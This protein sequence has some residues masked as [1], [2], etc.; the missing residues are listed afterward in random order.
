MMLTDMAD[1]LRAGGLAVQ[2]HAGWKTRT[3]TD[4]PFTPRGMMFHHDASPVGP[5]PSVPEYL[6]NTT[7]P[8]AQ[9]WVDTAGTWHTIAAGRMWHA[10]IG[11]GWG[12]IPAQAGNTY[13]LGVETDHTTGEAWPAAQLG[14]IV[15]G[16][17]VLCRR[18]GWDP[19]HAVCGHK[20]YAPGRKVDPAPL[21]MA[22]FR[23]ALGS[24]PPPPPP[25]GPPA[26]PRW[27]LPQGHYYGLI[28]GPAV[29]HGGYSPDERPV[30][31][32]LQQRLIA[33]GYVP[34][35]TRWDSGWADGVFEAATLDAVSR[36][37][38]REMPGTQFYGQVW[39]DDYAR[40]AR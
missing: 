35:V 15:K 28:T 20:E 38:R 18:Y 1:V 19:S 40:L 36:F 21:D 37:Q 26:L 33:K 34:G 24:P 16:F 10:G 30:I 8:G 23:S 29:S 7:H 31:K 17:T 4:G 6:A 3:Q 12:V 14:A 25:S 27:R 32:I 39:A 11:S 13:S 2:E 9:L 5:S 22:W